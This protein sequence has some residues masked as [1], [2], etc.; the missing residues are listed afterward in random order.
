[1]FSARRSPRGGA[2]VGRAA[3]FPAVQWLRFDKALI[4]QAFNS[5][6]HNLQDTTK[7]VHFD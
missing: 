2:T 5:N 6:Q 4:A 3:P 1:L 7:K